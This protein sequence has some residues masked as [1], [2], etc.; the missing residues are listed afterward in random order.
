MASALPDVPTQH[1]AVIYNKPGTLSTKVVLLDTPEPGPGQV[2]INL[3]ALFHHL[4][5]QQ[6]PY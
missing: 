4:Y 2:L 1:K 5:F 6:S 3:Y